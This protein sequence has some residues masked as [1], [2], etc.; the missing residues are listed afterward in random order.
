MVVFCERQTV[1][2]KEMSL[3]RSNFSMPV[4]VHQKSTCRILR[5]SLASLK[6]KFCYFFF[7]LML[8]LFLNLCLA[9]ESYQGLS[10][11]KNEET[12]FEMK[13]KMYKRKQ[14]VCVPVIIICT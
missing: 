5:S 6:I 11:S 12:V 8:F 10:S 14:Y 1:D 13:K 7:N 2:G 3:T 4:K 9:T